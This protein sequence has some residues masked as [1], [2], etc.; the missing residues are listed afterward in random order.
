VYIAN[1]VV[2]TSLPKNLTMHWSSLPASAL[3]RNLPASPDPGGST[4]GFD[5][6]EKRTPLSRGSCSRRTGMKSPIERSVKYIEYCQSKIMQGKGTCKGAYQFQLRQTPRRRSRRN[7][8]LSAHVRLS[9][10]YLRHDTE[11]DGISPHPRGTCSCW[12]V[13]VTSDV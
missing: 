2:V 7:T 5:R 3:A 6:S 13:E 10:S 11:R 12:R 1:E 9:D 8:S 4:H